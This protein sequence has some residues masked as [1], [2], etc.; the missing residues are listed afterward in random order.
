MNIIVHG[1]N[2]FPRAWQAR[3]CYWALLCRSLTIRGIAH[4]IFTNETTIS[5]CRSFACYYHFNPY[6]WTSIILLL[7]FTFYLCIFTHLSSSR[8]PIEIGRPWNHEMVGTEWRVNRWQEFGIEILDNTYSRDPTTQLDETRINGSNCLSE[9][10]VRFADS[11]QL[12]EASE[13]AAVVSALR[14]CSELDV[15]M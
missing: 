3:G 1:E 11:W 7:F 2:L 14:G 13:F 8:L 4:V 15:V 10:S 5:S 12:Y 9:N 6:S